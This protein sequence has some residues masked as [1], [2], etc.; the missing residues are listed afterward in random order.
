MPDIRQPSVPT[1][2]VCSVPIAA[3]D[4]ATAA[5]RIVSDAVARVP[6]EVHL[7]NAFTL[8]LVDDD[9]QMR[10]ALLAADLNLADGTPVAYLGRRHG[11]GRPV[12]GTELVGEVAR[13]GGADVRHYLYGGKEGVAD[14]MAAELAR[15]VPAATVVGTE[16][17]PFR[18]LTDDDLSGLVERVRA[19]GA[20]V[21][22]IGLG[23][24]R[25]D[26]LVHLLAPQLSIPVVP[27]GAAFDFWSGAI[28]EAPRMLQG[29]GLEWVYRLAK[30]PRR[31]WRR[32]LLGNPRFVLSAW[33]HRR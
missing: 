22:W 20:G 1:Y 23:T 15:V 19:S 30:E 12:R 17:P 29:T 5:A 13:Q 32:Y 7:C 26:Y 10:T 31:L 14:L 33:R 6:C 28:K 2:A 11:L 25:Q 16:C 27:V 8:S 4:A 21:L 24:P 18:P 3:V 9:E